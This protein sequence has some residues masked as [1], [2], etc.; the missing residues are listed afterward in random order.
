M[1]TS[2]DI[3]SVNHLNC[4]TLSINTRPKMTVK[5]HKNVKLELVFRIT[6][7]KE[8]VGVL[9]NGLVWIFICLVTFLFNTEILTHK[10]QKMAA[11]QIIWLHQRRI[12]NYS[13]FIL[14]TADLKR[15]IFL[16][17][18]RFS[19]SRLKMKNTKT[20]SKCD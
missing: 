20:S 5:R 8:K 4:K 19:L 15:F 16:D 6:R 12:Q 2:R 9:F 18:V 13:C 11:P 17:H 14:L 10:N 1:K 3:S 7:M